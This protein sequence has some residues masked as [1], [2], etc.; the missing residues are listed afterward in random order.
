M[1]KN[2]STITTPLAALT[3]AV[4]LALAAALTA[5]VP[6]I[7]RVVI[8]PGDD[9][10]GWI[11]ALPYDHMEDA[12]PDGAF[13]IR[14]NRS[15][16]TSLVGKYVCEGNKRR[17]EPT[18]AEEHSFEILDDYA[19]VSENLDR[20]MGGTRRKVVYIDEVE[21]M[22]WIC[23]RIERI[24][25]GRAG[26]ILNLF[27]TDGEMFAHEDISVEPY[28]SNMYTKIGTQND[29]ENDYEINPALKGRLDFDPDTFTALGKSLGELMGEDP[30][31]ES[32]RMTAGGVYFKPSYVRFAIPFPTPYTYYYSPRAEMYYCFYTS[33][34]SDHSLAAAFGVSASEIFPEM[35]LRL[36]SWEIEEI[37]GEELF[38]DRELQYQDYYNGAKVSFSHNGWTFWYYPRNSFDLLPWTQV[39]VR[40]GR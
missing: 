20:N 10:P 9:P 29:S 33:S 34:I 5:C 32:G 39:F 23:F 24:S 36:F 19:L 12:M 15:V 38:V 22:T 25:D 6:P 2:S 21:G 1:V 13:E 3:L 11:A 28:K 7:E 4:T 14:D 17:G 31:L 37:I 8:A 40:S 30:S 26:N 27:S 35:G 16:K 18:F